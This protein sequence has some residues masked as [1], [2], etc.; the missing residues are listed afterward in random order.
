[1][2]RR[3]PRSLLALFSAPLGRVAERH[4]AGTSRTITRVL[5]AP[6]PRRRGLLSADW[7]DIHVGQV[8]RTSGRRR[9]R[10]R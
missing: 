5:A 1:M 2:G 3:R 6:D 8:V 9:R 10:R 4:R 7:F